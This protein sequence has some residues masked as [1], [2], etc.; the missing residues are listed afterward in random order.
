VSAVILD[1]AT[2]AKLL[3][4][5]A[6]VEFRDEAGELIGRF[7]RTDGSPTPPPGYEIVGEW[8]SDEEIDRREREG[9][10]YSAAEVEA[11][12]AGMRRA[13]K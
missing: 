8:P 9:K 10:F 2:S 3:A 11:F 13:S 4:A 6:V 1:A 12:L 7:T 5:G